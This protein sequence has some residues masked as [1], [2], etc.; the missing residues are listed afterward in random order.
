MHKIQDEES[1][2]DSDEDDEEDAAL[3]PKMES[4]LIKHHGS[5]NRIRV[6]FF[7]NMFVTNTI[8]F[9]FLPL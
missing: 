1:D 5:V 2:S 8:Q 4:I 6:R 3:K 9:F 7:P